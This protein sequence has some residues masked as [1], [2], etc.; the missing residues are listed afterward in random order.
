MEIDELK[1][2]WAETA[3]RIDAMDDR[4]RVARRAT[5]VDRA[6]SR[7]RLM[8]GGL[9]VHVLIGLALALL[10]GSFWF[11]H[12]G[13]AHLV[14]AG[15]AVHLFGI[16]HIVVAARQLVA[17]RAL[18]FDDPMLELQAQVARLRILRARSERFLLVAGMTLWAPAAVMLLEGLGVDLWLVSPAYVWANVAA[19]LAAAGGLAWAMRRWPAAFENLGVG[20]GL[21]RAERDLRQ[22]GD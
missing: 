8:G 21:R 13:Q 3:A 19:G 14:I 17:W 20:G 16:L 1:T 11:G 12:W 15:M 10:G 9:L 7:L 18:R 2:A 4:A 22:L 5:G 6:R